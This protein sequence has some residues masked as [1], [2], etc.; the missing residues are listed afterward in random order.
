MVLAGKVNKSLVCQ[1]GNL[2][3]HAI[4]LCGLD[5]NMLKC[6]PIDDVHGYVGE[7]TDI[8][9]E[10]VEEAI[11]KNFIPV[12]STIGYDEDG[13]C[14]EHQCRHGGCRS[15]RGF[16]GRGTDLHDRCGGSVAR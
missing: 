1:I 7:I 4:G 2:G 12:I 15:G 6:R 11:S 9:M 14:Y 10:V 3:G 8:N 13:N 5:G 16:T